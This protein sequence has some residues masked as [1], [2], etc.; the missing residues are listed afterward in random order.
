MWVFEEVR[1][2]R[3]VGATGVSYWYSL[4]ACSVSLYRSVT[5]F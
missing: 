5:Y 4:I 3:I 2:M 1:L